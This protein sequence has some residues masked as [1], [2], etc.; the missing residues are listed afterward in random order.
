MRPWHA[1]HHPHAPQAPRRAMLTAWLLA[2]LVL[3]AGAGHVRA[4]PL[5]PQGL[6]QL[7]RPADTRAALQTIDLSRGL[8]FGLGIQQMQVAS[9][10]LDIEL[11]GK[12]PFADGV[13][14]SMDAILGN[15]RLGY[16]R[17]I[18]RRD[19]PPDTTLD[20]QAVD[21]LAFESDQLWVFH[22]ISPLRTLYLGY[23][24]GVMSRR[25]T[26]LPADGSDAV[27]DTEALAVGGLMADYAFAPPFTLQLRLTADGGGRLAR[28]W[29][30]TL[31]LAYHLPL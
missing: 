15:F 25:Y 7:A 8:R 14:I 1:L 22:G 28:V 4:Q 27:Q 23:G 19:L 3:T 12:P 24:A 5:A 20:G 26:L 18:Y 6:D 10:A 11:D 21:F 13:L 2:T 31:T 30:A 17:R 29:A 16:A 9:S